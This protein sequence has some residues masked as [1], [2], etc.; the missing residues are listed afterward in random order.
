MRWVK[1]A[2]FSVLGIAALV[3]VLGVFGVRFQTDGSGLRPMPYV[4]RTANRLAEIEKRAAEDRKAL[5]PAPEPVAEAEAKSTQPVS[6]PWPGFYGPRRDGVYREGPILTNWPAKGLTPLWKRPVG[7]GYGSMAVAQGLVF[8]LEQRRDEEAAVA[9]DLKTGREVWSNRWKGFFQESMGGD[10]PR[11]T[12]AWDEGRVYFLGAE[13]E[14]R[15]IDAASGKTL[16]RKNLLDESGAPNLQWGMATSP[17]VVGEFVVVESG[18]GVTAYD[19]RTGAKVWSVLE[20]APSYTAPMVAE[21][22]GQRQIIAV[23]SKRAVGLSPDGKLLWEFPWVTEYDTNSALPI[24]TDATHLLLTAGYGHGSA[25]LEVTA[26]GVR[27]LWTSKALKSKF[28]NAVLYQGTVYGMD[29]GI[30]AAMD[31]A[32]GQRRWKGG[33]YG[34]GQLLLAGDQLLILSETGEIALVK[35][36]PEKYQEI[37]RFDA[38]EGKTWNVPAMAEGNLLVRNGAEMACYRISK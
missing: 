12:P 6:A 26:N 16:W 5:P 15:C 36:S 29:D 22:G 34:F 14:F 38:I 37:A 27:E 35:A 28:N 19:K 2:L 17:L 33:R 31:V 21:L 11:S 20:D 25:L 10:G 18:K 4:D 23:L 7:L 1:V 8:T 32:T 9:Y 13:G 3:A 30:L 24:V